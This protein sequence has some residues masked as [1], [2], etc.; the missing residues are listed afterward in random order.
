MIFQNDTP[1]PTDSCN[2]GLSQSERPFEVFVPL[3]AYWSVGD[4]DLADVVLI[5]FV[6]YLLFFLVYVAFSFAIFWFVLIPFAL[7]LVPDTFFSTFFLSDRGWMSFFFFL[8][9]AGDLLFLQL[10]FFFLTWLC[11]RSDLKMAISIRIPP[12]LLLLLFYITGSAG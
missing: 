2:E 12:F 11:Q 7:G 6:L 3:P 1:K 8:S 10:L 5:F 9:P 4:D